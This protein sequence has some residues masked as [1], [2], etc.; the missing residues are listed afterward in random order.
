MT[1]WGHRTRD[2]LTQQ[3][4][5]RPGPV[6][7]LLTKNGFLFG[8][9]LMLPEFL[10][11]MQGGENRWFPVDLD[12]KTGP[13]IFDVIKQAASS[14]ALITSARNPSA[15]QRRVWSSCNALA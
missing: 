14:K 7:C 15:A 2:L 4:F 12:K 9:S 5:E 3:L 6:I 13:L 8:I 11:E 1:S 10:G